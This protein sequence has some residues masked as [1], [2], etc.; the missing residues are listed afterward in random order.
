MCIQI[1][2]RPCPH[3]PLPEATGA[4]MNPLGSVSRLVGGSTGS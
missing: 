4:H 3:R 2:V 1:C